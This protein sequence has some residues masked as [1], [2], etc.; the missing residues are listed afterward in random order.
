VLLSERD[1]LLTQRPGFAPH[2]GIALTWLEPWSGKSIPI[3]RLDPLYVDTPRRVRLVEGGALTMDTAGAGLRTI[4]KAALSGGLTGDPFGP[5]N[6]TDRKLLTVKSL[7]YFTV[8][9]ILTDPSINPALLQEIRPDDPEPL[10][11][12]LSVLASEGSRAV[13]AGYYARVVPVPPPVRGLLARR[14]ASLAMAVRARIEAIGTVRFA[15]RRAVA[16][17]SRAGHGTEDK[18]EADINRAIDLADPFVTVWEA[19]EDSRFFPDLW[20]ELSASEPS[21]VRAAW[22]KRLVKCSG[23]EALAFALA[24][25]VRGSSTRWQALVLADDAYR[26]ITAKLLPEASEEG[27]SEA[28]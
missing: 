18:R 26:R 1:R 3:D 22:L 20:A 16:T 13:G 19:D 21:V 10:E 4:G 24:N 28:I 27:T 12:R 9:H 5:V 14:D 17:A 8:A 7:N 6:L 2:G 23:A 15:I 11:L 25:V